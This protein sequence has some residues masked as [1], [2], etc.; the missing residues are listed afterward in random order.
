M[1]RWLVGNLRLWTVQG[2]MSSLGKSIQVETVK[3]LSLDIFVH[4]SSSRVG[5]MFYEKIYFIKK[6]KTIGE[7]NDRQTKESL[8]DKMPNTPL[9][10]KQKACVKYLRELKKR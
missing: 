6:D 9:F 10:W 1:Y 2:T 4:I 5:K 7:A 3:F 8:K